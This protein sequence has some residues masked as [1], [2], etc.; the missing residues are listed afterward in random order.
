MTYGESCYSRESS[1]CGGRLQN[2]AG[3]LVCLVYL[4]YLVYLV[5]LVC[6]LNQTDQINE[7]DQIDQLAPHKHDRGKQASQCQEERAASD[8]GRP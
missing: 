6:L 2:E 5:C 8:P 4:V 1:H 3:H 7:I